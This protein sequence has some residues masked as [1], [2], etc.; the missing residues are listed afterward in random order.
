MYADAEIRALLGPLRGNLRHFIGHRLDAWDQVR[1]D[2][3]V[4]A[5]LSTLFFLQGVAAE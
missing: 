3:Q 2:P 5:D 1:D 4:H